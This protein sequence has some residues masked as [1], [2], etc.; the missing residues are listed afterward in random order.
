MS[1]QPPDQTIGR[2]YRSHSELPKWCLTTVSVYRPS[3][4]NLKNP[5]SSL[6]LAPEAYGHHHPKC[7]PAAFRR[8][9]F[10]GRW[11]KWHESQW[12]AAGR[13]TI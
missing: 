12:S 6:S 11:L 8:H 1:N 3:G 5:S 4:K 7:I 13:Q 10:D 9:G 2:A